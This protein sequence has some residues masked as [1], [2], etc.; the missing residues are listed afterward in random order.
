MSGDN[1]IMTIWQPVDDQMTTE[2]WQDDKRM[3]KI[4]LLKSLRF[5][6]YLPFL[7]LLNIL[8]WEWHTD[9]IVFISWKVS[10]E[11]HVN[12]LVQQLKLV[13]KILNISDM[14]WWLSAVSVFQYMPYAHNT[15]HNSC[16]PPCMHNVERTKKN[17]SKR[18]SNSFLVWPGS[19]WALPCDVQSLW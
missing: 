3:A 4:L 13:V 18:K 1:R 6:S 2:W 19:Y 5:D 14:L 16:F 12:C 8:I 11:L 7:V 15:W 10:M 17:C 9:P